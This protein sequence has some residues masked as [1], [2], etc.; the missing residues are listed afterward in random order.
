MMYIV[1]YIRVGRFTTFFELE[2][3][4]MSEIFRITKLNDVLKF[5]VPKM[6]LIPAEKGSNIQLAKKS[7]NVVSLKFLTYLDN[8]DRFFFLL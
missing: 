5:Q 3:C 1:M 4:V 8:F 6:R 7:K 2:T